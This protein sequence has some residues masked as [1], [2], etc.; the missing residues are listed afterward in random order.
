MIFLN[1]NFFQEEDL[2]T[3]YLV[4]PI[5]Q[6]VDEIGGSD[7]DAFN[8]DDEDEVDDDEENNH[9]NGALQHLPSSQSN[10]RKRDE[11]DDDSVEDLRSSK[12]H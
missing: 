11:G 5:A 1:C 10:K 6:P 7:F 12:H 9:G 2:G 8:E 4:Q 3:E